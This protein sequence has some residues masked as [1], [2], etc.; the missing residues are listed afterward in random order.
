MKKKKKGIY[1]AISN[2]TPEYGD[3]NRDLFD[4]FGVGQI[5]Q[6]AFNNIENLCARYHSRHRDSTINKI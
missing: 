4:K 3:L 5:E 1:P 2:R 6:S